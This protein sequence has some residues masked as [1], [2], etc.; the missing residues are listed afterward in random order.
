MPWTMTTASR[1]RMLA[2]TTV[3]RDLLAR[4]AGRRCRWERDEGQ[5]APWT[6]VAARRQRG[7]R[8][9]VEGHAVERADREVPVVVAWRP[10]PAGTRPAPRRGCASRACCR[11]AR[12]RDGDR[13][14]RAVEAHRQ[15]AATGHVVGRDRARAFRR[16]ARREAGGG[17]RRARVALSVGPAAD[18]R[19]GPPRPPGRRRATTAITATAE[20]PRGAAAG[21]LRR[22]R[23][24]KGD[25]RP[26][27]DGRRR[28][29][30]GC[31]PG[32]DAGG[33]A[34][35]A[36]SAGAEGGGGAPAPAT[37]AAAAAAHAA[38]AR[39]H[40]CRGREARAVP[41][42][43]ARGGPGSAERRSSAVCVPGCRATTS[44]AAAAI[45]PARRVAVLGILGRGL[46]D[47]LVER[48]TSSG[49]AALGCG[50][51]L[52]MCAQSLA[53]SPSL[54]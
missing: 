3:S 45:S 9:A 44:R 35:A 37:P 5:D 31:E 49:R 52:L 14:R 21:A 1:L 20:P 13:Q 38:S 19:A 24:R 40:G 46:G 22:R 23:R 30:G 28:P 25:G 8:R 50:G 47:H 48:A 11:A 16:A 36:A 54:G 32:A 51:G 34:A 39:Q 7:D 4:V 43:P 33:G 12:G 18:T 2:A 10:R 53:M 42:R 6:G 27:A 29:Y 26:G 17:G 41:A 15:F